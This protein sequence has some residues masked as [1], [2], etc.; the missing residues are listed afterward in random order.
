M[1]KKYQ[2][3]VIG[4]GLSAKVFQIPYIESNPGFELRA[5]VQRSGNEAREQHPEATVYSSPTELLADERVEVVVVST[6]P[7]THFELVAAALNASK[8]GKSAVQVVVEKPFCPSSKECD[9]L[10]ALAE[11][12]GKILTVFQNRRWD[13]DFVTLK[14]IL[15]ENKLGRVVEFE[16]H[17]DRFDPSVPPRDLVDTPGS[18]VIYDLGTHLFD[19]ILNIY[20][21]P[22]KVT[23]FLS[24]QRE[25]TDSGGP[26]DACSVLLHYSSGLLA[27]VKAS[28]ISCISDDKQL[29]FL[30]RGSKGSYK[31]YDSDAQ[32]PQLVSG[33]KVSDP[34]F[35]FEE[36]SKA[37]ILTV[38]KDGKF[39]ASPLENDPP[40]TYSAFYNILFGAL[41]GK[42]PVPVD[43]REARNV[44]KLVE[45]ARES[46]EKGTTINIESDQ[47]L[48]A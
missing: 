20:G 41:E 3:G 38:G 22:A 26:Y 2:V 5:I 36:A 48:K 25:R 32:E 8:H 31:K 39:E 34:S 42:N 6:P 1:S 43:A 10:I 17:F 16:S 12:K 21:P 28:P 46:S 45:L 13:A 33:M 19:Q 24:R 29:R 44:I 11:N 35:G 9:E 4:Y 14:R 37:G 30:V 15:A 40:P 18:G 27:T 7:G 47:F 23:G